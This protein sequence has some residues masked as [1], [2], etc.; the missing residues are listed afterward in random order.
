MSPAQTVLITGASSGIGLELAKVFASEGYRL[1]LVARNGAKLEEIKK[2]LIHDHSVFVEVIAKDLSLPESPRQIFDELEQRSIPV[3]VLVNN[4]GIGTFGSFAQLPLA[5]QQELLR[6]NILSLTEMTHLFLKPMIERKMGKI[7]NVAS[8]AA[9]QPGPLMAAYYA[10]KAYV[11][12]FS[13]ALR[14]ELSKSGVSVTT[15]CPGPTETGFQKRAGMSQ[16]KLFKRHVM[17]AGEV[18]QIGYR[19]LLKNKAVVIPGLQNKLMAF[20]TRFAS[21]SLAASV[22]RKVQE[23]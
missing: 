9:F 10:S 3:D 17:T 1:V 22:V 5:S 18:A 20:S 19:G 21:R 4:A 6:L 12:S 23:E 14:N 11:L 13:E 2:N 8:I 15:L 7:L 16:S